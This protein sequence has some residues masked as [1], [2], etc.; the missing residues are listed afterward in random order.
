M[1][2]NR[3]IKSV[4]LLDEALAEV[5]ESAVE[6]GVERERIAAALRE[7]AEAVETG[8]DTTGG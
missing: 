3:E 8:N 6:N 7:R 5:V 4:G 2:T 1:I